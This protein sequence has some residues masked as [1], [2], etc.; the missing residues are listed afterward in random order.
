MESWPK[1]L[2]MQGQAPGRDGQSRGRRQLGD[3]SVTELSCPYRAAASAF[4]H[5]LPEHPSS[6]TAL[7]LLTLSQGM[8]VPKPH[9]PIATPTASL[10]SPVAQGTTCSRSSSSQPRTP[11]APMAPLCLPRCK[12][13]QRAEPASGGSVS[14]DGRG[15]GGGGAGSAGSATSPLPLLLLR[16]PGCSCH[17]LCPSSLQRPSAWR[18]VRGGPSL[19]APCGPPTS[20][21]TAHQ[22]VL[23]SALLLLSQPQSP[24]VTFMGSH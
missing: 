24:H 23:L 22:P 16:P 7:G 11:R 17:M 8:S 1:L 9:Q 15:G 4:H 2:G 20:A 10:H 13:S 12:G 5:H 14:Q 21:P 19:P 3:T 18:K 6:G